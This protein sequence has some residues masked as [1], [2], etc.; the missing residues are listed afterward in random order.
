M[1][2]TMK[3]VIKNGLMDFVEDKE[4]SVKFVKNEVNGEVKEGVTLAKP[5]S[6]S[7]VLYLD[8][9]FFLSWAR[10]NNETFLMELA[11][12]LTDGTGLFSNAPKAVQDAVKQNKFFF[13]LVNAEKNKEL[14][15]EVPHLKFLDLAVV[16]RMLVGED[17][18]EFA[19]ALIRKNSL[20]SFGLNEFD[21]FR[22]CFKNLE[23][24]F[25]KPEI[26][27]LE[28]KLFGKS[29]EELAFVVTNEYGRYGAIE[30][31]NPQV[32]EKVYQKIGG[33]YYIIPS[34][35]HEVIC[36]PVKDA[37]VKGL[38]ELLMTVNRTS[39]PI[40]EQLSDSLYR[41]TKGRGIS[42]VL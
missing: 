39:V 24:G 42:K 37:D 22:K 34:S 29:E 14:L 25:M 21:L 4:L 32:Q 17:Q 31:F 9:L 15:K 41:Y 3:R 7:P 28:E 19:S 23:S 11:E 40:E 30:I 16:L 20:K 27:G 36:C 8:D 1:Y 18:C 12:K 26:Q 33:D 6:I 38:H 35:L 10:R 2:S 5:N 13:Q